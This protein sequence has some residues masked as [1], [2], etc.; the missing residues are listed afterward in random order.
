MTEETLPVVAVPSTSGTGSHVT[1]FAVITNP[2]THG[3][4]GFGFP[5]MFPEVSIVDP[6][7]PANMPP[8][9]T[10]VTGFD[11]FAHASESLVCRGDHPISDP[12]AMRAM[13]IVGEYLPRAHGEGGDMEAREMMALADTYAGFCIT[14]SSA[15]LRHGM[16]HS[17]SGHYPGIPHGQALATLAVPIMKYNIE[18]GDERVRERYSRVAVALGALEAPSGDRDAALASVD[19]VSE[20]VET[21]DLDRSLSELGVEEERLSRMVEDTFDYMEPD[22]DYNP[23]EI[24]REGIGG[25]F[26][27]AF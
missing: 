11:V 25:I 19:A 16:S 15:H 18:N 24:G 22:V 20:L 10:A 5:S 2:E 23:V 21:L 12:L 1:P 14:V 9:L 4:P 27:E 6:E 3:K 26:R 17:V 7:I 13:E 8:G